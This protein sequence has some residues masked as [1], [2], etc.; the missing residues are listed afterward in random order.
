VVRGRRGRP[1]GL[2]ILT[3]LNRAWV[4]GWVAL[5]AFSAWAAPIRDPKAKPDDC[6]A[7]H[8]S[9]KVLPT[10]HPSIR[11]LN[12]QGCV[13]CH[14]PKSRLDLAGKLPGFHL[15]QLN[16]V[17]CSAC[18]GKQR[19]ASEVDQ[20]KCASCHDRATLVRQTSAVTPKNPHTSPHYGAE[21]DCNLCH[22]QHAKSENYCAQCHKFEFRVP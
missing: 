6:A 12:M 2:P 4:L 13:Q 7:C 19:R 5:I 15:H 1:P 20:D 9:E 8:R 16:G 18:H 17:A 11:G 14:A 3:G 21:L 10:G 22:H